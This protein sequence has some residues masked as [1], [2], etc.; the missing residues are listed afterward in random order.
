MYCEDCG[1]KGITFKSNLT[2]NV[3]RCS[4]CDSVA[5]RKY[6]VMREWSLGAFFHKEFKPHYIEHGPMYKLPDDWRGLSKDHTK[7][8]V[9]SRAHEKSTLDALGCHFGEKGEKVRKCTIEDRGNQT[10]PRVFSFGTSYT[11]KASSCH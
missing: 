3:S 1:K 7:V 6:G 9:E 5:E 8:F 11:R 10:T 2:G 4:D